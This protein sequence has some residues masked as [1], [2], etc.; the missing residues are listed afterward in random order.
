MD[1]GS[2]QAKNVID[3]LFEVADL[4]MG[5]EI[6]QHV[7][8]RHRDVDLL[9][10]EQVVEVGGGAIG[11]DRDDAQIVAVVENLRHLVGERH[12][13]A[14]QLAAGD[15]DG[16]VVLANLHS[17]IAPPCSMDFGTDCA[18]AGSSPTFSEPNPMVQ[19][20][21]ER[22]TRIAPENDITRIPK[23]PQLRTKQ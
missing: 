9:Q 20:N 17:R 13:G 16:P 12:V 3:P 5:A 15:A 4:A 8:L 14:R 19:A 11:D 23:P 22:T 18:C 6:V 7:G 2:G 21:S 1:L 10:I